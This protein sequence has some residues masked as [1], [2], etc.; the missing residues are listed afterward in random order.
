[1]Y[2]ITVCR[3]RL[4]RG[5]IALLFACLVLFV[6]MGGSNA[7]RLYAQTPNLDGTIAYISDDTI[8]AINTNGT[9]DRPLFVPDE[10]NVFAMTGLDWSP[11]GSTLAFTSNHERTC[12][13]Y[14]G[15]VYTMQANGSNIR[16]LTNGPACAELDAY[17]KGTV[18]LEVESRVSDETLFVVYVEGAPEAIV[19]TLGFGE[20][21]QVTF[22]GVADFG[23]GVLQRTSASV[24]HS[25]WV[26][27]SV[28]V[29]VVAGGTASAST[30][31]VLNPSGHY[32]WTAS[33]PR[34]GATATQL[35]LSRAMRL[36]W[37]YRPTLGSPM[38]GN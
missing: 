16:R 26:D 35:A 31:L 23:Q 12:S 34:G 22:T 5:S 19:V 9:N 21:K 3:T 10:R 37:V 18:V 4:G 15:D 14:D 17:P 1:M 6:G 27:P 29:D 25:R 28:N 30:R 20:V 38:P 24:G 32:K 7:M 11:D 2:P 13:V 8:R 33:H 36:W